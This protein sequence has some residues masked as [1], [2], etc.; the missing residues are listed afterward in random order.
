MSNKQA[1]FAWFYN[2]GGSKMPPGSS[3]TLPD[4]GS[5]M[6]PT[7]SKL[8]PDGST[9]ATLSV[10]YTKN[11]HIWKE[12]LEILSHDLDK[13]TYDQFFSN[14]RLHSLTEDEATIHVNSGRA[15]AWINHSLLHHVM[16]A[17]EFSSHGREVDCIVL[18][19][20]EVMRVDQ[21]Q[22]AG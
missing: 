11:Y 17:I 5:K 3:K 20:D 4:D 21:D 13:A 9:G 22:T 12:C 18:A 2:V 10:S 8:L 19:A 6:L 7:S 16:Q 15:A 1:E 14:S